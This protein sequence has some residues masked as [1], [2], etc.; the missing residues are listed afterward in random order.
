MKSNRTKNCIN[1]PN[2]PYI[3]DSHSQYQKP[4]VPTNHLQTP[5]NDVPLSWVLARIL[6]YRLQKKFI[7]VPLV[8]IIGRTKAYTM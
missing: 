1:D 2:I 4:E 8:M 5:Y 6:I 3:H 7:Q